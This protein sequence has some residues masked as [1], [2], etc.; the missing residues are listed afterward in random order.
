[1]ESG[2]GYVTA[3]EAVSWIAFH[4]F[5]AFKEYYKRRSHKIWKMED[6]RLLLDCF[7]EMLEEHNEQ[8]VWKAN[9]IHQQVARHFVDSS[10]KTLPQLIA[11]LSAHIEW[12]TTEGRK[13]VAAITILLNALRNG[14]LT[15]HGANP[16][17][18]SKGMVIAVPLEYLLQDTVKLHLAD[19]CMSCRPKNHHFPLIRDWSG[20]KISKARVLELWPSEEEAAHDKTPRRT[21]PATKAEAIAAQLRLLSKLPTSVT[22]QM[23]A[24]YKADYKT[25]KKAINIVASTRALENV[26]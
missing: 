19:N 21:R 15:I 13:Y 1:M 6:P 8:Y 23:T 4:D 18:E 7:Q 20:L 3:T 25:I 17:F 2:H 24:L 26:G 5:A 9:L 12:E 11:D 22:K 14:D 16:D 10:D